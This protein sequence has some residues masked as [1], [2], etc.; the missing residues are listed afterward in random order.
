MGNTLK[1]TKDKI[2]FIHFMVFQQEQQR[3]FVRFLEYYESVKIEEEE[4]EWINEP[5]KR[6]KK[7]E[8]K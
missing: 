5:P 1:R 6:K 7:K 8:K 3:D 4:E 2:E